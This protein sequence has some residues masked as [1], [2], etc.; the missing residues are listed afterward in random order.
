M[1]KS[2]AEQVKESQ[3]ILGGVTQYKDSFIENGYTTDKYITDYEQLLKDT[4]ELNNQQEK[5][6]AGMV[7]ST[8]KLNQKLDELR[9]MRQQ[10]KQIVKSH[11]PIHEWKSFG[12][13]YRHNRSTSS[14]T[15]DTPPVDS[16]D[17][18]PTDNAAPQ[19]EPVQNVTE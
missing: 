13:Q 10:L 19:V 7:S 12:M 8:V 1:N 14:D 5:S 17:D 15:P 9:K 6:K 18:N 11:V 2:Y 3:V 4:I 16:N